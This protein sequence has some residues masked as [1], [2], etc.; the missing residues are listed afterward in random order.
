VRATSPL[1]ALPRRALA[2]LALGTLAA[3]VAWALMT[4]PVVG[5]KSV[6]PNGADDHGPLWQGMRTVVYRTSDG[7]PLDMSLFAPGPMAHPV[8]VVLDVH[9]G[10]WQRGSRLLAL[11]DS[12]T[13]TDLVGA[14]LMVASIDYRLAPRSPWPDQIIDVECAL[15]YLRAHAGSLGINPDRVGALGDS[16]GGQLVSLLATAPDRSTWDVGPNRAQSNRVQAVVD[17]FGPAD[18]GADDW[19]HQTA[20]MIRTV[21]GAYPT[22][23][24]ANPVLKAA[25]PITYVARGDPPFLIVQG[26]A[27]QVVPASQ[28]EALALKLRSAGS[29]VD[30][31]LVAR[32]EH[33]LETPGESPSSGA[34]ASIITTYLTKELR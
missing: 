20:E 3:A 30:L 13:A 25:S 5:A 24:G 6:A 33:G 21:F 26:R 8:P 28:S 29:P 17:E 1:R 10:G 34:I 14:G 27:D 11:S 31:V 4:T 2:T 7:T 18:L 22:G 15:R 16:A 23:P 32:G 19:P 9:G 12:Q